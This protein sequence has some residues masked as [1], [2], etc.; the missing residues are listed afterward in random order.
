MSV[1]PKC[2][3]KLHFYNASQFCPNCGVNMRFYNF[4]DNFYLQAKKAELGFADLHV[5]VRRF[6][7][8]MIGSPLAIARLCVMLIPLLSVLIPA[9]SAVLKLPFRTAELSLGGIGIYGMFT[10]TTLAFIGQMKG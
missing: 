6:K 8:A 7:A 3:H 1:C 5:K 4:E 2:G 10:D 9:A